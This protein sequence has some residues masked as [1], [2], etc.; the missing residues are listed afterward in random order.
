MKRAASL[1][2]L[3]LLTACNDTS[4]ARQTPAPSPTATTSELPAAVEEKRDAIVRAARAQD[5]DALESLLDPE[6][7]SYSFA[8]EGDPV[9][10]WRRLESE[11]HVPILGDIM[12]LVFATR[13]GRKDDTYVWPAAATRE[14]SEW[15]ERDVEDLLTIHAKEDIDGYR[16]A[17]SYLGWR[18]GIRAD[19][20]WL[21]FIA[22]D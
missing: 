2:F 8:E 1:V 20:T 6:T 12:P 22:G 3:A 21:Y 10:Y 13:H 19:G 4:P 11:G 15:S 7:F 5:L 16:E 14:P 18:A 9:G 17:G